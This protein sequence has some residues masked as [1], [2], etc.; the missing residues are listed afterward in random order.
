MP[1]DV[2]GMGRLLIRVLSFMGVE[3]RPA[4]GDV[5]SAVAVAPQSHVPAGED[6]LKLVAPRLAKNCQRLVLAEAA[7]IPFELLAPA[8][9]PG[10][11]GHPLENLADQMLLVRR[12]ISALDGG[13]S[14]LPI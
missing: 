4:E 3:N 10:G 6:E 2:A 11:V 7:D 8:L 12:V 9:V 13:R 14:N 1:E 5:F